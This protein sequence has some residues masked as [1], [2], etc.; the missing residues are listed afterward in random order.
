M[1]PGGGGGGWRGQKTEEEKL[2]R[3]HVVILPKIPGKEDEMLRGM[4]T[5]A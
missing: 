4:G 1:G 5:V 2:G 3:E